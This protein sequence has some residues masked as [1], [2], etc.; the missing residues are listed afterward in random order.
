MIYLAVKEAESKNFPIKNEQLSTNTAT[1]ATDL[2][3]N[4]WEGGRRGDGSVKEVRSTE[5]EL[6]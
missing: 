3:G 5:L 1:A 4:G 2:I 6:R